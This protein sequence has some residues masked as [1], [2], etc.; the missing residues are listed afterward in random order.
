M[1]FSG[2]QPS[3]LKTSSIEDIF[4]QRARLGHSQFDESRKKGLECTLTCCRPLKP[5]RANEKEYSVKDNLTRMNKE[6]RS[7]DSPTRCRQP[8]RLSP[9]ESPVCPRSS[10]GL[11]NTDCPVL[12][13]QSEELAPTDSPVTAQSPTGLPNCD[14]PMYPRHSRCLWLKDYCRDEQ[15]V[16]VQSGSLD[17]TSSTDS[18]VFVSTSGTSLD[19]IPGY[20]NKNQVSNYD[21]R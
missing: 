14:S 19:G 4:Q 3:M 11:N 20:D 18:A 13:N 17:S 2:I 10:Q 16:N 8:H 12:Q 21:I 5:L 15:Q 7:S 6:L 1:S 9:T